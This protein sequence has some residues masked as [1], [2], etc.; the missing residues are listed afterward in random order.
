MTSGS[1]LFARSNIFRI[2]GTID[3]EMVFDR[4]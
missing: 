2:M 3:R 1:Q 4:L